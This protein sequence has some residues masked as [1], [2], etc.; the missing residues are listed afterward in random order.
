MKEHEK[1]T[2]YCPECKNKVATYDGKSRVNVLVKCKKCKKL[3]VYEVETGNIKITKVP[4][5]Q[6]SSGI[7]FY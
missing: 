6:S 4:Q 1:N 5:R 3:V 7:R 2:I